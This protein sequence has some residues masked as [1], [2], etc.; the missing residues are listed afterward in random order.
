MIQFSKHHMLQKI[1]MSHCTSQ[2]NMVQIYKHVDK[3]SSY[4][5]YLSDIQEIRVSPTA[6]TYCALKKRFWQRQILLFGTPVI[7]KSPF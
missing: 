5:V 6:D 2:Y 1:E 3:R 7:Q 4:I